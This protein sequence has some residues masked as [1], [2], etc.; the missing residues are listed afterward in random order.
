MQ[1]I[2]DAEKQLVKALP[3][4][5][6]EASSEELREAIEEH[7]ETTNGQV[8]RLERAF[9]S[10]GQPVKGRSCE[11]MKGLISEG[12]E[13]ME[14]ELPEPFGDIAIIAAAQKVEHYEIAAYGTARAL[15]EKIGNDDVA[16]LLQETL[17]EEK[18]ADKKL[19]EVTRTVLRE[20]SGE[21]EESLDEEEED[22]M[23]SVRT[24]RRAS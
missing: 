5:A 14:E 2:Y 4:M 9:E 1:D 21:Q 24:R 3:K 17:D 20:Y 22:E 16:E 23:P 19:T 15:A 8:D 6:K 10:L 11:G 18:E 13:A 12:K 7:L